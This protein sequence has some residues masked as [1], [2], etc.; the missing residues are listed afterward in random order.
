MPVT[1]I[2]AH[3]AAKMRDFPQGTMMAKDPLRLIR[4]AQALIEASEALCR[5]SVRAIE[6]SERLLKS[7]TASRP[8]KERDDSPTPTAGN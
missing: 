8:T 6:Q 2:T 3:A 5:S 7:L 4:H 1:F